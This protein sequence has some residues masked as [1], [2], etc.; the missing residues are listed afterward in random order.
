MLKSL[1]GVAEYV[2][3][4][5]KKIPKTE[6]LNQE[7]T[8][9][10]PE[11]V[12]DYTLAAS[13]PPNFRSIR[14]VIEISAPSIIR[15]SASS[16]HPFPR[17]VREA[18]REVEYPTGQLAYALFPKL[19]PRECDLISITVSYQLN[20]ISLLD[21]L[22][23][24]KKAHEPSGAEKNE[25]WMSAQL[26]H[27]KILDKRFGRFDLRDIDVTVDVGVHNE[28]KTTVPPS[29]IRRL[30]TFFE[31]MSEVDPRQQWK[32]LP[33]L[34]RL[35]RE[36]TAGQ[37]FKILVDLESLFLPG[38]FSKYIDVLKDFRYSGCYKGKEFFELPI[39]VIP[40]KMNI[41]SRADLT[42]QK[43]AADGILIYKNNLFIDAIK[44]VVGSK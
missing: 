15:V 1:F 5:W 14:K 9:N 11:S 13:I 39:Q 25:Y 40:K 18:I 23:D 10:V 32:A 22:V 42:L 7:I 43:P 21:D 6:I 38:A 28:L 41:I 36:K 8:I 17:T 27:P 19:L 29:F 31:V 37:E 34:R 20:D 35:A 3:G 16:L 30:K 26:K 4:I 12:V 24:R 44:E 33:K 2:Y